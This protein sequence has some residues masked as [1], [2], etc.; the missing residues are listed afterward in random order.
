MTWHSDAEIALKKNGAIGSLSL[1]AERKFFFK[2]KNT[3][4]SESLTLEHGSLTRATQPTGG[5]FFMDGITN[6]Y[7]CI[8]VI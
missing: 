1:G 2:H 6:P 4:N 7:R 5:Y 3:K 8:T